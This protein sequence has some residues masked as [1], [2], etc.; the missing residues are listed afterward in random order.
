MGSQP[1]SFPL[2]LQAAG[3]YVAPRLALVGDAAHA[4]HPLAGQ[5]VNLGMADATCL[6]QALAA[7]A[8]VGRD[9]GDGAVL[10]AEYEAPARRANTGM[11]AALELLWRGFGVQAP[12][13]GAARAAGLGLLNAAPPLKNAIM[14][15][16]MGL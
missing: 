14:R 2:Q 11:M 9:P 13:P 12:L 8:A 15:Y 16:A 3:R 4:V 1:R 6:A 7:G 5:G 10:A